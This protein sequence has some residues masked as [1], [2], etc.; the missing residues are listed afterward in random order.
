MTILSPRER[1]V[2]LLVVERL[3]DH[4]ISMVLMISVRTVQTYLERIGKKLDAA[5]DKTSRRRVIR[6]W[7]QEHTM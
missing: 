7:T 2:A 3:S 1:E 4:E 6:K 5:T